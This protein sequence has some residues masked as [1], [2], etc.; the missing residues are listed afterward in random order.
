LIEIQLWFTWID[1]NGPGI[2]KQDINNDCYQ[3]QIVKQQ[4]TVGCSIKTAMKDK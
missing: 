1:K 3:W 4:T 2:E